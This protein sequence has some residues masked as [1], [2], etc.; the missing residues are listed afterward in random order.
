MYFFLMI[1]SNFIKTISDPT[2]DNSIL[3][4]VLTNF[5]ANPALLLFDLPDK[6]KNKDTKE[7][8][9]NLIDLLFLTCHSR[10]GKEHV[11]FS[12]R[13]KKGNLCIDVTG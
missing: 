4:Q 11:R 3:K 9:S 13:L 1:P 12:K 5:P 2:V 7:V 10:L 6:D 8:T